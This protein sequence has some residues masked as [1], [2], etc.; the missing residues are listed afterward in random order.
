M[1]SKLASRRVLVVEDEFFVAED[2]A[3]ALRADGAEVIGP[4][5]SVDAALDLLE[6]TE[7]LDGAVVDINLQGEKA[8]AVADALLERA[9][10]FVFA[11]GY[12]QS[13]ISSRYRSIPRC[14]K[15]VDASKVVRALFGPG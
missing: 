1:T 12:D 3:R 10:P 6:E 14:E 7:K 13:A 8:Y 15:P 4:A 11:T 9:I 5:P 2:I